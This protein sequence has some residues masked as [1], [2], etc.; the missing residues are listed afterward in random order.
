[1]SSQIESGIMTYVGHF[2]QLIDVCAGFGASYNPQAQSL[3]ISALEVQLTGVQGA[4]NLVDSLLPEYVAAESARHKT[5][6][7]MPE[8]ALRVQATAIVLGLPDGIITRI[9]EVI[10]KIRGERAHKL[11]P[12]PPEGDTQ[13]HISVSQTSFNEQI[14]HFNQLI[15]LAISQ[16][17]Y[18]PAE[19][20]IQEAALKS[21]LG[22]MRLTNDAVMAARTPL[23][24]A[25][26]ERDRLLF[27]PKTGMI[28]TALAVKEYVK[29]VFGYNSPQYREVNHISFRNR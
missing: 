9:K 29:A 25:R 17:S 13:K 4:I 7:Q 21:L 8:I 3:T 2:R 27:T 14:E 28:D 22:E 10:R 6:T 24:T 19:S 18:T 16:P 11:A 20:D 12:E 23:T 5:F 26:H 1:M 15:D